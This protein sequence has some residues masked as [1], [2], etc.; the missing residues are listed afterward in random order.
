MHVYIYSYASF[1][2]TDIFHIHRCLLTKDMLYR[3][4][5]VLSKT[6]YAYICI[7][8]YTHIYMCIYIHMY[9]FYTNIYIHVCAYI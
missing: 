5:L 6:I 1:D 9:V 2:K 4:C 8:T 7:H 3:A